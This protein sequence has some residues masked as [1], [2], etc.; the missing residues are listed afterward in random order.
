MNILRGK[1]DLLK[2]NKGDKIKYDELIYEVVAVVFNTL[3]LQKTNN[4][5][6]A[7]RYTMEEV[8]ENYRDIEFLK[9]ESLNE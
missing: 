9:E 3:Y 1:G 7:Y 6:G 4:T 8:Y 5:N 2:F